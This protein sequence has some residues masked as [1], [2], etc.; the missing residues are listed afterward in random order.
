VSVKKIQEAAR[1][2]L[3]PYR[4]WHEHELKSKNVQTAEQLAIIIQKLLAILSNYD[5]NPKHNRKYANLIRNRV[6]RF[7]RQ[8]PNALQV[9]VVLGKVGLKKRGKQL[10]AQLVINRSGVSGVFVDVLRKPYIS[11]PKVSLSSSILILMGEHL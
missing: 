6:K 8:N 11:T 10:Y 5:R 7:F 2:V 9:T 3:E 1:S 4:N